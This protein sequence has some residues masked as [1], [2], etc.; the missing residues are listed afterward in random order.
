MTEYLNGIN[1]ISLLT[2]HYDK[3]ADRGRA[4][5][6]II[7][8]LGAYRPGGG[9]PPGS[10]PS[11]GRTAGRVIARHINYGLYRVEGKSDCPRDAL[12][13][14][15]DAVAEA[16]DPASDRGKLLRKRDTSAA[17]LDKK[18]R[19]Q[20]S[21]FVARN[22]EKTVASFKKLIVFLSHNLP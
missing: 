18:G 3:V 17:K 14:L 22:N 20:P 11:A 21:F 9:Y 6:Q 7:G 19:R 15:P 16:G 13:H 10:W 1:A 5:Y 2:T 8:L 4:H 12:K